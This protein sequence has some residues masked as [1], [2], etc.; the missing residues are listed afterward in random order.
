MEV[1]CSYFTW[2]KFFAGVVNV[3]AGSRHVMAGVMAE[4]MVIYGMINSIM[5]GIIKGKR[6]A[7]SGGRAFFS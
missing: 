6:E 4:F 2:W 1:F 5:N 3:K 7:P